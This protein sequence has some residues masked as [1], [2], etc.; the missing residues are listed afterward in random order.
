MK[1][2]NYLQNELKTLNKPVLSYMNEI[3]LSET[4]EI[5]F[6]YTD[7][8]QPRYVGSKKNKCIK[9]FSTSLQKNYIYFNRIEYFPLETFNI[10]DISIR[11][12]ND[13]GNELNLLDT[14]PV[15]CTLH[16]KIL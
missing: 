10:N 14:I 7:I 6:V 16:F 8:I 1:V 13:E 5:I 9:I 15:Y 11:I 3:V 12:L 4:N 2:E